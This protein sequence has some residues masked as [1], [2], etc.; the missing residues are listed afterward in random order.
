ME[1][2]VK[3]NQMD[4]FEEQKK[5]GGTRGDLDNSSDYDSDQNLENPKS[6]SETE[7][8]EESGSETDSPKKT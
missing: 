6:D 2:M 4:R 7:S 3:Q 5:N 1:D 8:S